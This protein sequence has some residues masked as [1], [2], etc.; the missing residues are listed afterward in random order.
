MTAPYLSLRV[1]GFYDFDL[2]CEHLRLCEN[3]STPPPPLT[4]GPPSAQD[5]YDIRE[6]IGRGAFGNAFLVLHR[7]SGKQ[8]VLKKIRL[9]RQTDW[10][11]RSSFQEMQ[12]A[13]ALEHP[14]VVPHIESWV[15]RGYVIILVKYRNRGVSSSVSSST[16]PPTPPLAA[17]P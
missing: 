10:Q 16:T 6:Q 4:Q 17:T 13:M 11:R 14:F 1:L 3:P 9:A 7:D 12:V 8:Y 15:D 2:D 5:K